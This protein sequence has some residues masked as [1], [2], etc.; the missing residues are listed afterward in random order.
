MLATTHPLARQLTITRNGTGTSA[1]DAKG[2]ATSLRAEVG[3]ATYEQIGTGPCTADAV[4]ADH[5]LAQRFEPAAALIAVVGADPVG[6]EAV[7]GS[8]ANHYSFD[9]RA[10]AQFGRAT[11]SGEVWV[12]STG[13][14]IV[15]YI[16][17]TRA[18]ADY[19]GDG[20]VGAVTW[21]YE[22][23]TVGQPLTIAVPAGCP[24]GFVDAPRPA[25]ATE[26]VD[27]PGT[28]TYTTAASPADV[29]SFYATQLGVLGWT[30]TDD[31]SLDA[32]DAR[33]TYTQAG[34]TL[35]VTA[36]V[37]G[38]TTAVQLLLGP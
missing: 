38:A 9:E 37:V 10:L 2:P 22:L 15:K 36:T 5:T 20:I 6:S 29:A 19:F 27:L 12:A 7:N 35:T 16:V 18:G 8:L 30:P 34:A 26:V 28:C 25:D 33:A 23:T 3:G 13:G 11:S 24:P 4:A 31:A 14:Y 32:T 17:T 1:G 21:D